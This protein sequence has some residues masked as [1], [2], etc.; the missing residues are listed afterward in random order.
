MTGIA[1]LAIVSTGSYYICTK[2]APSQ[3]KKQGVTKM[4]NSAK[5]TKTWQNLTVTIRSLHGCAGFCILVSVQKI[6]RGYQ[7]QWGEL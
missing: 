7:W 4:Q 2:S 1:C 3:H 6:R 5:P